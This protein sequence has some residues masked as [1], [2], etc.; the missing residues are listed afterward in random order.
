[1]Q[2]FTKYLVIILL[3][4]I[5]FYSCDEVIHPP[6]ES[7]DPVLVID[8]WLNNSP[9]EQKINITR[10]QPYFENVLPTGVGGATVR[11]ADQNGMVYTFTETQPGVYAWTPVG[12]E[13]F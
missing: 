1:M 8:A 12:N 5:L 9:G 7:T 3:T 11:V 6:L 13:V 10:S 4:S 2:R